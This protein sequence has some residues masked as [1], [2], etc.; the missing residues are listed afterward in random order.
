MSLERTS[1]SKDGQPANIKILMRSASLW[2]DYISV[3]IEDL[4][5][6]KE[7][8]SFNWFKHILK[9]KEPV[10]VGKKVIRL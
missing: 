9:P 4:I 8:I 10:P 2:W 7:I 5:W 6:H 1:S 3:M